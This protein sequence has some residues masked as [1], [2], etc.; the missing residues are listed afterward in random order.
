MCLCLP[1]EKISIFAMLLVLIPFAVILLYFYGAFGNT[2]IFP[3]HHTQS[4]P[5][6]WGAIIVFTVGFCYLSG[7]LGVLPKTVRMSDG[8]ITRAVESSEY[9][10]Q[11]IIRGRESD[12]LFKA[13]ATQW[14][15]TN[16][17]F[18]SQW[19]ACD[20]FGN[21]VT[22][23]KLGDFEGMIEIIFAK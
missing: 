21:D 6:F 22:N 10:R 5:L 9:T 8:T 14:P 3:L 11:Y 17:S 20:T 12:T 18:E 15:F 2:G 16:H 4:T 1:K 23:V 7:Q 13:L 19:I